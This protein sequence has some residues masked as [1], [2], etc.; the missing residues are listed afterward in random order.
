MTWLDKIWDAL[1]LELLKQLNLQAATKIRLKKVH[2]SSKAFLAAYI[3]RELKRPLLFV[4]PNT[5]DAEAFSEDVQSL[6]GEVFAAYYPASETMHYAGGK[7]HPGRLSWRAETLQKVLTGRLMAVATTPTALLEKIQ[8]KNAVQNSSIEVR[9]NEDIEFEFLLAFLVEAGIE[10]VDTVEQIGEFAVRGG[11][12]DIFSWSE[13]APVRLEFFGDTIESIRYIDVLSQ[14]STQQIDKISLFGDIHTARGTTHL[15]SH[16]D[17]P[18][19]WMDEP[20]IAINQV[21]K[22]WES[23]DE[24]YR[25]ALSEKTEDLPQ[26]ADIYYTTNEWQDLFLQQAILFSGYG[27][28]AAT[29][30]IALEAEPPIRFKGNVQDL[31]AFLNNQGKNIANLFLLCS[32]DAQFERMNDILETDYS[33]A[34]TPV[35]VVQFA[36][37]TGFALPQGDIQVLT[38]HEIFAQQRRRK[39][40]KKLNSVAFLRTLKG[41]NYNDY[42]VHVDHGIG[43]FKGLEKQRIGGI[44]KEYARLE[45]AQNESVF[46]ALEHLY[47]VQK[48]ASEDSTVPALHKLGGKIWEKDKSKTRK[49]VDKIA[50]ELVEIY[51]TRQQT[52]GHAFA[53]DSKWQMEMEA[54]F[55]YQDTPDQVTATAD[56]KKDMESPA[57]MDRLICGD[58]GFGKTEVAVRA[59]FKAAQ[60][61]KQVAVLAPTTI[62]ASQHFETFQ[63]RLKDFPIKVVLLSRFQSTSRQK[64]IVEEI[65]KG[66]I[67]IVVGTHRIFSDD[68][69]FKDLG[70]LIVDE[71]QRFGVKHKEKLKR[72]RPNVDV[73]SMSATPIPRTLHMSLLGVRG[74]SN[75][76]TPPRNRL[77]IQTEVITWNEDVLHM[78]INR[79]LNRGGQVFFVHNRIDTISAIRDMLAGIVPEARIAIAHGQMPE[80]ELEKVMNGFKNRDYDILVATMI[81]ENGLD[82]PSTNTIFINRSDKFGLSQLYQLRGRVGRSETQAYAY[83]IAP[84]SSKLSDVAMKRLNVLEEFTEL[85][86][87]FKLALRDLEIRGAGNLLGHQ[88]SGFINAV[89]FD[90]YTR[91]LNDAI[92]EKKSLLNLKTAERKT[93]Q[94]DVKLDFDFD[95]FLPE[96]YV[97][98]Q[99][100]RMTYYHRFLYAASSTQIDELE[101]ELADRFGPL[102]E[103]AV[104]IVAAYRLRQVAAQLHIHRILLKRNDFKFLIDIKKLGDD[105]LSDYNFSQMMGAPELLKIEFKQGDMFELLGSIKGLKTKDR[106]GNLIRLLGQ[107]K[108]VPVAGS[109]AAN[110]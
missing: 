63:A 32:N 35:N 90:M 26:P 97:A 85:G 109:S 78:A 2:G 92:E 33:D 94:T 58:V 100:E 104:N 30:T 31:P 102:P 8:D 56:V 52:K 29:A 80:R 12:V 41:L 69:E 24:A 10:R 103:N 89:G 88:Q 68:V 6:L 37:S 101:A 50:A 74:F 59:A 95:L 110:P 44:L 18:V 11:I 19:I 65:G 72:L 53:S 82:I 9:Q 96:D 20:A 66:D 77:P 40:T 7:K 46:V 105:A 71:E 99:S 79:E 64:T 21:E 15:L 67:D 34:I 51:A 5:S 86:A 49:A 45:Y 93:A 106:V 75:I 22:Q 84:H 98:N 62:L 1:P 55:P 76:E 39:R 38:Y 107:L 47:K 61:S 91:I 42:I 43:L 57:P 73:L 25:F 60:D 16:L 28:E 14:R 54:S 3:I 4:T 13:D 27:P 81:I 87:G 17:N 36:L 23:Y 108:T 83:L 70:L 48:Y